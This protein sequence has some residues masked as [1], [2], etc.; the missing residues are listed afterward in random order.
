MKSCRQPDL[1]NL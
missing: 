1:F